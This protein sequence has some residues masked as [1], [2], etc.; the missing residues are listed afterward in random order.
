MN[1][2]KETSGCPKKIEILDQ[3]ESE[4]NIFGIIDHSQNKA[5]NLSF[6][7][8]NKFWTPKPKDG[9]GGICAV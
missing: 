4:V 3:V 7:G 6:R 2:L 5:K 8:K 9:E 1:K